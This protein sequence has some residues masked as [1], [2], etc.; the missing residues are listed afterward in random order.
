MI[1]H[2]INLAADV[3]IGIRLV[4]TIKRSI[5]IIDLAKI[6]QM[7]LKLSFV[8]FQLTHRRT[9]VLQVGRWRLNGLHLLINVGQPKV[10]LANVSLQCLPSR[11]SIFDPR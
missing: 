9:Y 8:L 5:I 6:L 7:L 11:P 1:V 3:T 10:Q 2:Y 4:L